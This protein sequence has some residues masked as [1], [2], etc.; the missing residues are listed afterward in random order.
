MNKKLIYLLI[1]ITAVII[2]LVYVFFEEHLGIVLFGIWLWASHLFS[3]VIAFITSIPIIG[4]IFVR[5]IMLPI[6]FVVG[7]CTSF[8][9]FFLTKSKIPQER[10]RDVKVSLILLIGI[11]IGYLLSHF[12]PYK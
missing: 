4:P 7:I 12:F 6:Q 2:C 8:L 9:N 3:V 10:V 5:V 11:C 1:T